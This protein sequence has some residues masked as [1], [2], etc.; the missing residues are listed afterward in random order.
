MTGGAGC[1][2]EVFWP[3]N[4][5]VSKYPKHYRVLLTLPRLGNPDLWV[6]ILGLVSTRNS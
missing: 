6:E 2:E 5:A 1:G 3:E 4:E